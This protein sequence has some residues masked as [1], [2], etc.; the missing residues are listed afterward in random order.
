MPLQLLP[1][2]SGIRGDIDPRLLPDGAWADAVNCQLDREGR[3][4]GRAGFTAIG[5][6][7]LSVGA[8]ALVAYDL[9]NY[10]GR[11]FAVGDDTRLGCPANYYEY[12]GSGVAQPWKPT[13]PVSDL[14]PRL[15]QATR[16][17]DIA[18]PPDQGAGSTII[19]GAAVGGY[20]AMAW[21]T[22]ASTLGH[23]FIVRS[24]EDQPIFFSHLSQSGNQP[25]DRLRLVALSDR[26]IIVGKNQGLNKLSISKFAVATDTAI[27][28]L[29]TDIFASAA[30][31]ASFG[32]CKVAGSDQFM[33]AARV[34]TV[35]KIRRYDNTGTVIVPSGGQYADITGTSSV[36]FKLTVEASATANQVNI[37]FLDTG[38]C[39]VYS[40][41]L[42]T[43]AD[44][45][46]G[47][48][49]PFS[50]DT[51]V[52]V[53]LVRDSATTVQIVCS[54]TTL[55]EPEIKTNR[56]TVSSN[57]FA[58][59]IIAVTDAQLTTHA[60]LHPAT[61]ALL[62]GAKVGLG[63]VGN[64]PNI[65]CSWL[66]TTTGS[67]FEIVK[68]LETAGVV[69]TELGDLAFDSSNS[70]WYWCNAAADPDGSLAP[71][72]TEFAFGATERRQTTELGGHLYIAGG[73]PMVFDGVS[74]VES[75]FQERPRIIS[76]TASNQV[77]SDLLGGAVYNY[78]LH[79]ECT[80]SKSDLHL[81][82]PSAIATVT[83]GASDDNILAVVTSPHSWRRSIGAQPGSAVTC[84][85]SRTLATV[86]K[87]AAVIIGSV[88]ID[89]PSATLSG[90]TLIVTGTGSG[91]S[92]TFSGSATTKTAILSEI[93]AITSA[94][95][96][97]AAPNG[98]LV[99]TSVD[100]GETAFI[101][102]T[103]G[104]ALTLL[105]LTA[106]ELQSGETT[107]TVG[108]N[109][110]RT[111]VDNAILT[112]VVAEYVSF[113]DTRKDETDPIADT[114]LIRQQVLYSSGI[115]SGAH[116]APPPGDYVCAGRDRIHVSGQ[117]K[118]SRSTASKII[119]PSEPAEFA[120]EGFVAFQTQVS[121]D[122]EASAVLGD[123]VIHWTRNEIW[124]V[125]GSGPGRNG[126]GEFFAARKVSAAG[127]LVADG[128]RS[129]CETDL[130][131]FFQRKSDQLCLLSKNGTVEWVGRAIQEYLILYPVITA[132]VYLSSRHTVAF[133]CTN[134]AGNTGGILRY[135]L[136]N[137]A[138]FFDNVGAVTAIS[139][140][141]GRLVYIQAGIVYLE[142]TA[143][144][145]GTFVSYSASSGKFQ[146]FQAL[147]WGQC[148]QVGFL[149]TF[150]G[151]CTVTLTR[152]ANG[153]TFSE[154]LAAWA[155]TSSEYAVGQQ[156]KLLKEPN[157]A[158]QDSFA[159][160]LTVTGTSGSEGVW[161]HALAL[162]TTQ[163]PKLS[164]QGPA[165]KL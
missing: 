101:N 70:R 94:K 154:T 125:T 142:D 104:T 160:K 56:Y 11:L 116:H 159:L 61:G 72:L 18:R 156:V 52:D 107:R 84:V 54:V 100:L 4:V 138:W 118:R 55:T 14:T 85:L 95:I 35:I 69:S 148:N 155:L 133:S 81:S 66:L 87:T 15:G 42:A 90:L 86:S 103:S 39:S 45:G 46:V 24:A 48:F 119:V 63:S 151:N 99:L 141:Q 19:S 51:C 136:E 132:A 17:R 37:A 80:D 102:V 7:V 153:T 98:I 137:Q 5:T 20:A 68:D 162:D 25:V 49:A 106:G 28:S 163:A 64:T 164:R 73:A 22:S 157:P 124:E 77:S 3:L 41:N 53:T 108:E 115:A 140:Y 27:A 33:I 165:H 117:P 32:V 58:G 129:L 78:R 71:R 134:S 127:G 158:M 161:L 145:V 135:D 6:G 76:L 120:F 96:T 83:M 59:A 79:W 40:Y 44:I 75:G 10:Q 149:G 143:P 50:G 26:F 150:R 111:A 122:I 38:A 16:V 8:G 12:L 47:P 123:S 23:L 82:P 91:H 92:V 152:S 1:F 114:D 146:G 29:A 13:S 74:L 9:V 36:G 43:G 110:Q 130:G 62:F 67:R 89:P 126:Q 31:T 109:F 97:A 88:S 121:G 112:E 93:N 131:I 2:S 57:T 60:A 65:L 147:G 128:W 144:G 21:S 30:I 34:S 105:G 113:N 139:Q